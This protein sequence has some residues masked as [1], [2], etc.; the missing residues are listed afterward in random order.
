MERM[1]RPTNHSLND[2]LRAGVGMDVD[3]QAASSGKRSADEYDNDGEGPSSASA[4]SASASSTSASSKSARPNP[5]P[6]F[7]PSTAT[8]ELLLKP[9]IAWNSERYDS[10]FESNRPGVQLTSAE[11]QQSNFKALSAEVKQLY[12]TRL[13]PARFLGTLDEITSQLATYEF[14]GKAL[15]NKELFFTALSVLTDIVFDKVNYLDA[16]PESVKLYKSNLRERTKALFEKQPVRNTRAFLNQLRYSESDKTLTLA[17]VLFVLNALTSTENYMNIEGFMSEMLDMKEDNEPKV[18]QLWFQLQSIVDTIYDVTDQWP[19]LYREEINT[20]LGRLSR[21]TDPRPSFVV[22]A[23]Q[24]ADPAMQ[25]YM[26]RQELINV[27]GEKEVA[28]MDA[29]A[30]AERKAELEEKRRLEGT[31]SE[32]SADEQED[33]NTPVETQ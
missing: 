31:D 21:A 19:E 16:N 30:E 5:P 26:D 15:L 4:P 29:E 27:L 6:V 28:R 7:D 22:Y 18:F 8:F 17:R 20:Y 13:Q 9:P 3:M 25:E 33:E 11:L 23:N 32:A 2:V 14:E 1:P 24:M 12:D 10:E